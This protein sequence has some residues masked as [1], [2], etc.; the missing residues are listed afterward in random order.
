MDPYRHKF[1]KAQHHLNNWSA[2]YAAL[3]S[4]GHLT[5][6]FTADIVKEWYHKSPTQKTPG[7]RINILI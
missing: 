5:I 1:N 7:D 2:Y 4:R 3:K 6:R